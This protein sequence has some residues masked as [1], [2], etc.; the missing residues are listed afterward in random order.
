MKINH[1]YLE[2]LKLL[3]NFSKKGRSTSFGEIKRQEGSQK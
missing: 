1:R 3:E 2:I